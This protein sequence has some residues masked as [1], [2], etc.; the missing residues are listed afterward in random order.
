MSVEHWWGAK[1]HATLRLLGDLLQEVTF[2]LVVAEGREFVSL[3]I[4]YMGTKR[5]LVP[6]LRDIISS[7][8]PG[9]F[10][11]AFSG[12]C[13]VGRAVAPRRQVW[14]NDLQAFSQLVAATHFCSRDAPLSR[15][16]ALGKTAP[17]K[18][19]KLGELSDVFSL[20]VAA[21]QSALEDVDI[22]ALATIFEQ[23][24]S[25]A[26]AL[27]DGE[28]RQYDLFTRRYAGTY[29]GYQQAMEIDSIRFGLDLL[30]QEEYVTSDQW[31]AMLVALCIAISRCSNS[32]GHFAQPLFPKGANINKVVS[33]RRR[34]I[35]SEW[36]NAIDRVLPVG[37]QCWRRKNRSFHYNASELLLALCN[38]SERPAV[39]YADPPYTK[40]QYSR[41][42]HIYETA[43]LYDYPQCSGV[44]LY[45]SNRVTSSF[46]LASKVEEAMDELIM[47]IARM[48][49]CLVLSYPKD[50]LLHDSTGL[51]P[52]MI[53]THF[54]R[55]PNETCVSH[56]HST[57]GASKGASARDVTEV[58]YQVM[59]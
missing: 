41:Y 47:A 56:T 35:G 30:K 15:F 53:R 10:L 6:E 11:D 34:S 43:V 13:S 49:S 23:S 27:K 36:L 39:V 8:R 26:N 29:F 1:R 54:G 33:K 50:G 20:L 18:R 32:T 4:S 59:A 57:M 51:I 17:R 9:I 44:G 7:C 48:G 2:R 21:E 28:S 31:Q 16:E 45:R 46:S 37:S 3:G 24:V 22:N 58:I 19:K 52:K 12:M 42:Y 40:D 5:H 38:A 14:S 55:L 25:E